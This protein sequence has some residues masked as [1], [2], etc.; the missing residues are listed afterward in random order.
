MSSS[1][2][3]RVTELELELMAQ[4]DLVETLNIEL[5][6]AN[7]RASVLGRRVDRLERQIEDLMNLLEAPPSEQPP[8]Y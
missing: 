1:T 5:T 8:H 7:D 2:E 3:D 4:R 6:A